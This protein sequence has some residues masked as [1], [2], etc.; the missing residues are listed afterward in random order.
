MTLRMA[1]EV[2]ILREIVP[3]PP[4]NL[5]RQAVLLSAGLEAG[6]GPGQSRLG[7]GRRAPVLRIAAGGGRRRRHGPPDGGI[8]RGVSGVSGGGRE[9]PSARFCAGGDGSPAPAPQTGHSASEIGDGLCFS[10][11]VLSGISTI[12]CG[13]AAVIRCMNWIRRWERP[14]P[15]ESRY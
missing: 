8:P 10:Y 4:Y 6:H 12:M 5:F 2:T 9:K 1:E 7:A 11:R 14:L 15:G 3:L 13:Q